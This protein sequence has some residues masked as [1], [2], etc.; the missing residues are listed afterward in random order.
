VIFPFPF[1]LFGLEYSYPEIGKKVAEKSLAAA[2]R[3]E[4]DDEKSLGLID[5]SR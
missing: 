3:K 5:I 1:F 2:K 4:E